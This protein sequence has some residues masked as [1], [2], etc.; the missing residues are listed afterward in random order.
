MPS[1]IRYLSSQPLFKVLNS[2]L[3]SPYPRHLRDL[4]REQ[5]LSVSGVSDI[6]RRLKDEGLIQE[7]R[8]GNKNLFS[9][10]LSSNERRSIFPLFQE[11]QNKALRERASRFAKRAEEKLEWMD[12]AYTF[13]RK[14]KRDENAA[15]RAQSS[16]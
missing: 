2:L 11:F 1:L 7:K 8:V 3:L 14:V 10:K 9:L 12:E 4:A 13:Y 5:Q 15:C 16:R 6:V